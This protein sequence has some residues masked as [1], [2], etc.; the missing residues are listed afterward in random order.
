MLESGIFVGV[1]EEGRLIAVGG[2]HVRTS[3]E[4]GI[5]RVLVDPNHRGRGLGRAITIAVIEALLSQPHEPDFAIGLNCTDRNEP[6]KAIYLTL[7]FV[8]GLAYEE[9]ELG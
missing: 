3:S 8:P 5:A 1:E 7:G 6:A 4:A 9:C 2:T